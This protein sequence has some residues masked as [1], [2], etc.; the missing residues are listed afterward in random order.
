MALF[1]SCQAKCVDL[2]LASGAS[3]NYENM[4]GV[5]FACKCMWNPGGGFSSSA[6]CH[7]AVCINGSSVGG[8]LIAQ[9]PFVCSPPGLQCRER[10]SEYVLGISSCKHRLTMPGSIWKRSLR[11]GWRDACRSGAMGSHVSPPIPLNISPL[12]FSQI[13]HPTKKTFE[14]VNRACNRPSTL[15][16]PNH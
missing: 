7:C 4:M 15:G 10:V 14:S 3:N 6:W 9:V 11:R 16:L 5:I 1:T 13:A 12:F 8:V 2:A